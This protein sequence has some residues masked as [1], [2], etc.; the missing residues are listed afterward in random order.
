MISFKNRI[1]SWYYFQ[2]IIRCL[3]HNRRLIRAESVRRAILK[4]SEDK[5][6]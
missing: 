5:K 1:D 4:K 3:V 6:A 2:K